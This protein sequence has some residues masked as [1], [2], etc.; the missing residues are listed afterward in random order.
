MAA[1]VAA[2]RGGGVSELLITCDYADA[3][4]LAAGWTP[5]TLQA[6]NF[7]AHIGPAPQDALDVWRLTQLQRQ[8]VGDVTK[9]RLGVFPVHPTCHPSPSC[10][11]KSLKRCGRGRCSRSTAVKGRGAADAGDGDVGRMVRLLEQATFTRGR[12]G[13]GGRAGPT[14]GRRCQLQ[15]LH[16]ARRHQLRC[17]LLVLFCLVD[18]STPQESLNS[19]HAP[20]RGLESL[21]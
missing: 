17:V 1:L 8:A 10:I 6:V 9:S 4:E 5:D 18:P 11:D 7:G 13:G 12:G 20:R 16:G 19:S 3:A 14:A 2:L 15:H 21:V